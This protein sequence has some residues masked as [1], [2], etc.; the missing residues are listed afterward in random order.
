MLRKQLTRKQVLP[1]LARLE[2]CLVGMEA[3]GGAH[4]W[5]REIAKLG[6]AARLMS[7][8][9]VK[10]YRKSQKN[11][12]ND[13]EA[14]CEA[15]GRLSMRFVPV[16]SATQQDVQA[17]H[18]I[19]FQ[20][21]KWRTALANE[22]RGLLDEYG[23]VV[24]KG[25][26]P[27]RRELPRLLDDGETQ[28]SGLFREMLGEMAER[29]KLLDQRIHQYDLK[30]ERVFGQDERCRRLV[31]VEGVGPLTATALVAAVGNAHEFKSGRELSAWLGLV[32]RQHS[33]GGRNLLL[34]ISK[35]ADR[36]LRTLLIH[37][38]R[39]A[40]RAI[41]RRKDPCGLSIGRL[42]ARRGPN[43]AAVALANRNARVLWALLKRGENYRVRAA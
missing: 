4:Y 15:A 7:P 9:F 38:A 34:N 18:R 27:L 20:L 6:H 26:A 43:I 22:I 32:P 23:I 10:P 28:L 33:S 35:R 40:V 42:K 2:P 1:F 14:V 11:D 29:L 37:G 17:L 16:K 24:A 39:S 25:I 5:A 31:K 36:Y 8:H 12:G 41:E 19:R 21:I 13:A 3:C 30:V